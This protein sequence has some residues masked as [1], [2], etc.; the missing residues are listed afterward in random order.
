MSS[1]A[2]GVGTSFR[3]FPTNSFFNAS[4]LAPGKKEDDAMTSVES[5]DL[6][7]RNRFQ[8]T[9]VERE[10]TEIISQLKTA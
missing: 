8:G 3:D 9:L 2:D 4:L 10:G 6:R 5:Q 7:L 1:I